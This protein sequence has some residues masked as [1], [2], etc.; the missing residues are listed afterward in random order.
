MQPCL[1]H[2]M[3]RFDQDLPVA[4]SQAPMEQQ[5]WSP[6]QDNGGTATGAVGEDFAVI[7]ADTRLSTG[8]RILTRKC[9]KLAQ[10]TD[11]VYIASSGMQADIKA[12]Q[13]QLKVQ[14]RLYEFENRQAPGIHAI[15]QLLSV[16]LYGRRFFPYYTFNIIAG[17][18]RDGKGKLY[19]YDAV[20]SFEEHAYA[21]VGSGSAL[22]TSVL[23][24]RL[25][26]HTQLVTPPKLSKLEVIDLLKDGVSGVT[27]R[28]IFTGDNAEIVVID[29][30]GVS[31]S[32]MPLRQD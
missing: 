30:T 4:R 29:S 12:L 17:L 9:S 18:D 24:N 10:L 32:E 23:D 26:G 3:H 22:L 1:E 14:V 25:G 20:G 31:V 27:E 15:A 8:Y 6:Y 19:S 21:A 11:T 13:D 2:P 7:V 16:I 5:R 28:D